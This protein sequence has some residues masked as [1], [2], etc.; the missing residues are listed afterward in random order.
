M[1]PVVRYGLPAVIFVAG[2]VCLVVG[3]DVA[4]GAGIVLIGVA[5]LVA[6]FGAFARLS[7]A[8]QDDREREEAARE[9]FSRHGRW[10][11]HRR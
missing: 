2:I 6:V 10:P 7:L 11:G 8:S 9:Y 1:T 3:G 4:L 5:V